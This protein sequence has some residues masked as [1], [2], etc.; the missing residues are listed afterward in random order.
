MPRGPRAPTTAARARKLGF[1]RGRPSPRD[2]PRRRL[3]RSA[4][5]S[6][7]PRR[8]EIGHGRG[9]R[10]SAGELP[11]RARPPAR[12]SPADRA[13]HDPNPARR[14]FAPARVHIAEIESIDLDARL[15]VTSRHLTGALPPRVPPG[16][17]RT[18][19]RRES[20]RLSGPRRA[21][22]QA[23]ALRRLLPPQESPD[24][25]ARARRHRDRS[26]GAAPA[27]HLLR[28][29]RRFST[30]LACELADYLGC[31][32]GGVPADRPLGV[33]HRHRPSRP[34]PPARA[35]RHEHRAA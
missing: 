16:G 30:E 25:D 4:H 20:R 19:Q 32:R 33:P 3:C 15:V 2:R 31:S 12:W 5:R 7:A 6:Q 21:R 29:R 34:D 26:G 14:I 8:D 11:L 28:G 10:C 17:A 22:L 18:R 1:A 24:R 23:E 9:D 27:S 35:V 13:R